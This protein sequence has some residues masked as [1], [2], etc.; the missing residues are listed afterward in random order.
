MKVAFLLA[1]ETPY[2]DEFLD[3]L[4]CQHG[5][6]VT[7]LYCTESTPYRDWELSTPAHRR[8]HLGGLRFGGGS[9]G[10]GL[11]LNSGVR[12][13]LEQARPDFVVVGGYA[14][15]A[16][17]AAIEWARRR[18]VPYG[19]LSESHA[20]PPRP[21][22]RRSLSRVFS[23]RALAGAAVAFGASTAAADELR[24]RGA[25]G[26]RVFVLPN[27]PDVRRIAHAAASSGSDHLTGKRRFLFVGRLIKD[28]DP[29]TLVDAF[30]AATARRDDLE[31]TIAGAGPLD[32][33]LRCLCEERR[34]G[35]TDII[36]FVQ[37]H[38]LPRLYASHDV[39]ALPSIREPF[40]VVVLEAMASGLPVVLS[41]NVGCA[42]DLVTADTGLVVA[43]GD[44]GG[45]EQAILTMAKADTGAM[46][47]AAQQRA[48]AWDLDYC[49]LTFSHAMSVALGA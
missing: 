9:G 22:W 25:A 18:K 43:A 45:L 20:L 46:G 49:T 13:A 42:D 1:T 33:D 17:H 41:R 44:T 35:N 2:R 48:F 27:S 37:P 7:A 32:A 38:E 14:M 4:Q 26:D 39:F 3:A 19:I 24:R 30:A 10:V 5:M 34:L 12:R 11:Q 47:L 29:L 8:V 15:P 40:G 28:K 23:R 36:G 16:A 21:A 31:L 6:D